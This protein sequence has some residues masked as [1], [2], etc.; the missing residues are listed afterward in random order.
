MRH[1]HPC[2]AIAATGNTGESRPCHAAI[3]AARREPLPPLPP[4]GE[5]QLRHD[6]VATATTG[7]EPLAPRHGGRRCRQGIAACAAPPPQPTGGSRLRHAADVDT[8]TGGEPLAPA[9]TAGGEPPT[10]C[11]YCHHRTRRAAWATPPPPPPPGESRSRHAT[12]G[13]RR[14]RHT[15]DVTA[16]G[17]PLV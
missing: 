17:E 12:V 5:S 6:T 1:R 11:R 14:S 3:T 16:G 13:E 7:K 10:P 15:A 4:P 9:A 8:T 2:R